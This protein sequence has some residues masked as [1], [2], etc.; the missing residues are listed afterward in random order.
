MI[1]RTEECER[2]DVDLCHSSRIAWTTLVARAAMARRRGV[3]E[4]VI[5]RDMAEE[6]AEVLDSLV[7][8]Y[9]SATGLSAV[10]RST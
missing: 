10:Q 6:L 8:R 4:V 3:H 7:S 1:V 2:S 9:E 5:S